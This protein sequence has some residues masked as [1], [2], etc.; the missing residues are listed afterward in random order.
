M[1]ARY[2]PSLSHS[3][4]VS[5]CSIANGPTEQR[6]LRRRAFCSAFGPAARE[7]SDSHRHTPPPRPS[8]RATSHGE[9]QTALPVAAASRS[10]A[11]ADSRTFASSTIFLSERGQTTRSARGGER[12]NETAVGHALTGSR[13]LNARIQSPVPRAW[14]SPRAAGPPARIPWP[15]A[16]ARRCA[17]GCRQRSA[18][19]SA[20][21][22]H[23]WAPRPP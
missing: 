6:V 3:R 5:A 18:R 20:A 19:R 17:P 14:R 8:R 9:S 4:T 7:A 11:P 16:R 21:S 12:A 15:P 13:P 10:S 23:T 22:A 2:A 1:I